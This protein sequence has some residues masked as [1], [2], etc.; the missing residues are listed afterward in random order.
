MQPTHSQ[1][2]D[3]SHLTKTFRGLRALQDVDLQV[4][5][6]EILGIIGPNGAGK[7]TLFNCLTGN[8]SPTRG[9]IVFQGQDIS[10]TNMAHTVRLGIARTFQNIRLFGA[11]SVLDNVRTA[12]QLRV[13]FGVVEFLFGLDSFRQKEHDLT[14]QALAHL[15]LFGLVDYAEQQAGNLPYGMQRRLE[16]VRALATSPRLLL[17]DEPAAGMNVSETDALHHLILEVKQRFNLAIILVEHD[18]RL[19]MNICDRITVLNYGKVLATGTPEAIR[20]NPDVIESYLGKAH[21]AAA[22]SESG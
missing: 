1:L 8:L 3:V 19:V 5:E 6:N 11:L 22:S 17:L 14:E 9:K 15:D 13:Q 18:M 10:Q 7:T 21:E 20:R 2:L 16:I 12:Q 4:N